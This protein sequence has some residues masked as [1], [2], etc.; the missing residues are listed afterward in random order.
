MSPELYTIPYR[1]LNK[2]L[3]I[4]FEGGE[5]AGKTTLI[6]T[7]ADILSRSG[8][9]VVIT[10]EPG[11]T[12]FGDYL[13]NW[14]LN[15]SSEILVGSKAELLLFLASRAQHIEEL[16]LPSLEQR[17]IVLCDRFSDSTIA[18]QGGARHLGMGWVKQMC[19]LV[20][21][22]LSPDRTYYLDID[23]QVGLL[24]SKRINKEEAKAGTLDHM[25]AQGLQFHQIVREAFLNLAKQDSKRII[26]ID[27][28]L[29]KES[30]Y[31]KALDS[32]ISLI[33]HHSANVPNEF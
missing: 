16:I 25:E 17:K 32:L 18:Y 4:T 9:S 12:K 20:C 6:K 31:Q 23:P 3:F 19:E 26:M 11:G 30:I 22:G 28:N 1:L 24:R 2:G 27:A 33:Q 7:L 10:R 5:G 15:R 14:L 29:K 13:R 21:S 8:Y